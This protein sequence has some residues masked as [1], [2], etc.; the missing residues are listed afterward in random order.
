MMATSG[1]HFFRQVVRNSCNKFSL[2]SFRRFHARRQRAN[3]LI[4][5][6][7]AIRTF[8]SSSSF[9]GA[10]TKQKIKKKEVKRLKKP[11]DDVYLQDL[12]EPATYELNEAVSTL[13]R[14]M[15]L[16]LAEDTS[17]VYLN[18]NLHLAPKGRGKHQSFWR[19]ADSI[20]K[21]PHI[22]RVCVFTDNADEIKLCNEYGAFLAGGHDIIQRLIFGRE[23]CDAFVSTPEYKKSI[24]DKNVDLVKLMGKLAPSKKRGL[25]A[26][27]VGEMTK[28]R[29]GVLIHNQHPDNHKSQV[30]VGLINQ[31]AEHLQDNINQV[32]EIVRSEQNP[33]HPPIVKEAVVS[34][35]EE[36]ISFNVGNDDDD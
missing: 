31:S 15:E 26:D 22:N 21:F 36:S 9:Q 2:E 29:D 6:R 18:L 32:L 1:F 5:C 17:L 24:L 10:V 14:Y 12:Y 30:I 25:N 16:D 7:L 27:I 35:C 33:K 4:S 34:C 20:H 11:V 3:P 8:Q 23:I 13:K 19:I 28:L